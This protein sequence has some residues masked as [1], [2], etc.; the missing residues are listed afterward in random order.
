[1]EF[2]STVTTSAWFLALTLLGRAYVTPWGLVMVIITVSSAVISAKS[3]L[4]H[5]TPFTAKAVTGNMETT[6][7]TARRTDKSLFVL[8]FFIL[9]S[10]LSK[11]SRAYF[12][13]FFAAKNIAGLK[14][15]AI[16]P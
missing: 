1:M 12:S 6:M 14:K 11:I 3:T 2:P 10:F 9:F 16:Y 5:V 4:V 13:P 7:S 8:L 15:A